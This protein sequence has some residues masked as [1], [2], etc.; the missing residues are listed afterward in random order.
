[1]VQPIFPQPESYWKLQ[2]PT[3]HS[4][5]QYTAGLGLSY[6]RGVDEEEFVLRRVLSPGLVVFRRVRRGSLRVRFAAHI[7]HHASRCAYLPSAPCLSLSRHRRHP[8]SR[9]IRAA[10]LLNM[11][12][13]ELVFW[14]GTQKTVT[15]FPASSEA[16]LLNMV[17]S[18]WFWRGWIGF[19]WM[20]LV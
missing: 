6:R 7:I 20:L 17:A 4:Q 16:P 10:P 5:E 14:R 13:L 8:V 3:V 11:V 1:M 15:S 2:Y 12:A 9:L 19:D 18:S